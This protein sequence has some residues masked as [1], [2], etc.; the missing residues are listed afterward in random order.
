MMSRTVA[1]R[2]VQADVAEGL[3]AAVRT[4]RAP[5]AVTSS[6]RRRRASIGAVGRSRLDFQMRKEPGH[7]PHSREPAGQASHPDRTHSRPPERRAPDPPCRLRFGLCREHAI[8]FEISTYTDKNSEIKWRS[9][10]N[11]LLPIRP[12]IVPIV[13]YMP[14]HEILAET[15]IAELEDSENRDQFIKS[16][17]NITL[18]VEFCT[19]VS[20]ELKAALHQRTKT[21]SPSLQMRNHASK[22]QS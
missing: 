8:F 12:D 9:N 22:T 21:E 7:S 20:V 19:R 5:S 6:A 4:L 2:R 11:T 1:P 14:V 18:S 13:H 3:Q 16:I 15:T 10:T 17:R